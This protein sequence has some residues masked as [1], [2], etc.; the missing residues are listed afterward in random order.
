M[1]AKP[2]DSVATSHDSG[3]HSN[4]AVEVQHLRSPQL[5]DLLH[6]TCRPYAVRVGKDT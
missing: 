4:V 1:L 3:N 2:C 6:T 5:I